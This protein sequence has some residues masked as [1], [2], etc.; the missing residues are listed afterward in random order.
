[1]FVNFFKPIINNYLKGGIIMGFWIIWCVGIV[2]TIGTRI[3]INVLTQDGYDI[4]SRSKPVQFLMHILA[5]ICIA[6]VGG[7]A[8]A[9]WIGIFTNVGNPFQGVEEILAFILVIIMTIAGAALTYIVGTGIL[10][11]YHFNKTSS[12]TCFLVVFI[13]S[14]IAWSIP[15]CQYNRNIETIT[16]NVV[17]QK[18]QNQL[19]YFCNIPVQKVS[20]DISGSAILGSGGVSGDISTCDELPY[21][22]LNENG[23]GIYNSALATSSKMVFIEEDKIPYVEVIDYCKQTRTTNN[24]NG[25]EEIKVEKEW[26][27][28][29]FY[30]HKSII[31]FTLG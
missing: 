9:K 31:Q 19:I 27:E 23:E 12:Q 16:E 1:M 22:Y 13:I 29:Y 11:L 3:A 6:I 4:Y 8:V 15:I 17:T 21:W 5:I 7:I 26:V 28:Y 30:L 20:G 24:N 25:K 14:I 10:G 2:I 18:Q